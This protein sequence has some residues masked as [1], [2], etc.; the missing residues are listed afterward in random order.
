MLRHLEHQITEK[1]VRSCDNIGRQKTNQNDL[2][3]IISYQSVRKTKTI[4]KSIDH[5][6]ST[7]T[8]H[9]SVHDR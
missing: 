8:R 1:N 6:M 4:P 7:R 2:T 9:E 5:Q 3:N